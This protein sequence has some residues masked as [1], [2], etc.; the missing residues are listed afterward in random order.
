MEREPQRMQI[1]TGIAGFKQLVRL[2]AR[3]FYYGQVPP[4]DTTKSKRKGM[5]IRGL[6]VVALDALTRREWVEEDQLALDL[7]VSPHVL[8]KTLRALE[9]EQF[10]RREHRKFKDVQKEK[11]AAEAGEE[12]RP[13]LAKTQSLCC[14]DYPRVVEILQLR[15]HMMRKKLKDDLEESDPVMTYKCAQCQKVYTSFDAVRLLSFADHKLHCEDC[16]ADVEQALGSSG[17]TGDDDQRRA[18]KAM[19][20]KLQ[21]KMELQLKPL[22]N[23]L[24][25]VK[26][27]E[28]PDFGFHVDW[29]REQA[30]KAIKRGNAANGGGSNKSGTGAGGNPLDTYW[31]DKTAVEVDMVSQ[32]AADEQ[33]KNEEAP[34]GKEMPAWMVTEADRLKAAEAAANAPQEPDSQ[35]NKAQLDEIHQE[36]VRQYMEAVAKRRQEVSALR[37]PGDDEPDKKRIKTEASVRAPVSEV[38]SEVK[39]EPVGAP[40]KEGIQWEEAAPTTD[41]NHEEALQ[42]EDAAPATEPKADNDADGGDDD[43]EWED[44]S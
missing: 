6:A 38:K 18:R 36:Y 25:E 9:G 11:E 19:L 20:K 32:E 42:W 21:A 15:I 31:S 4:P 12:K 10:L 37:A 23:Q 1:I 30:L 26:D 35:E 2:A 40:L 44:A 41:P 28:P 27:A 8:R 24:K 43:F 14:I 33:V 34:A 16:G 17:Q 3:C 5:D 22:I 13:L 29:T 7:K 39:A